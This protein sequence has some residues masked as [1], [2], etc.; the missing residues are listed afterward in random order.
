MQPI[1]RKLPQ[2]DNTPHQPAVLVLAP[3]NIW[4]TVT[5]SVVV[6]NK[7]NT[8]AGLTNRLELIQRISSKAVCTGY[9]LQ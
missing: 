4:R 5:F 8:A 7:K 3:Q 9:P 6:L 1:F 2:K